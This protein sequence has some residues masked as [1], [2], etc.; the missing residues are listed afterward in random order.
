MKTLEKA[1]REIEKGRLWRAK[2]ILQGSVSHA[3]Y[4]ED[5][6]EKLGLVL[7][8]MGDLPDAGKYL[9]L[10]GVRK[11]EYENAIGIFLEKHR[12]PFNLFRTF[13]PSAKL[14]RLSDYPPQLAEELRELGFQE[15]PR[16]NARAFVSPN[17]GSNII[18]IFIFLSI[19]L[20]ILTLIILGIVKLVEI[21]FD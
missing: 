19:L 7:L 13:P 6:F 16:E 10:S 9:F 1:E 12:N 8:Q 20:G 18:P 2:E 11:P 15:P 17:V 4:N 21:I 3:T 5:V 14:R